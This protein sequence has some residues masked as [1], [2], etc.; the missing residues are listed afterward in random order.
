[1]RVEHLAVD[2]SVIA[3]EAQTDLSTGA[4]ATGWAIVP[5][6]R[7]AHPFTICP[8]GYSR[9]VESQAPAAFPGM[10]VLST[11][12][13]SLKG[14]A[15]RVAE[16]ELP[17]ATGGVRTLTIGAWEGQ[18]GC[19]TTSLVG[20]AVDRLVEI[21][22]TLQFRERARGLAIDSPVVARPRVPE[23]I[24]EV[25]GVGI[26][27]IQPALPSV[28]ERIPKTRGKATNHGELFRIRATSRALTY[29]SNSAVVNLD[30]F[31]EAESPTL[32]SVAQDLR[33]EW[34][35]ARGGN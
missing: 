23:V 17:T 4:T 19:L 18:A 11:T 34:T 12:D 10:R 2:G 13:Y 16:V 33:I 22:D 8:A 21:F 25:P 27:N 5:S 20:S 30:P 35:P 7:Q 32:M 15:L 24:K 31:D 1:M 26:L 28:L 14:G 6:L 9:A 29:V 3:I